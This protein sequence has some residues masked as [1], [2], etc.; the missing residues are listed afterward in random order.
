M[1]SLNILDFVIIGLLA[2]GALWGYGVGCLRAIRPSVLIFA[3]VTIIYIYPVWKDY[4][5]RENIFS[6]FLIILLIFIG[7]IIWGFIARFLKSGVGS[8]SFGN[9]NGIFGLFLGLILGAVLGGFLIFVLKKYAGAEAE[10]II[11]SSSLGSS[12]LKFFHI[13]MNFIE[14]CFPLPQKEPWWKRIFKK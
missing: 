6:F 13:I 7:L 4:F 11:N 2:G 12:V 10:N 1:E 14:K 5:L 9:L 8:S 3:L